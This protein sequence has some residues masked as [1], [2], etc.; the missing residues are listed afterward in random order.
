MIQSRSAFPPG[1]TAHASGLKSVPSPRPQNVERW[2]VVCVFVLM[3][4]SVWF[5]GAEGDDDVMRGSALAQLLWGIVYLAGVVGLLRNRDKLPQLMRLSLPIVAIVGLATISTAWSIDPG[6]TLK[7]AFGLFGTTAFGYYIVSRY[8]LEDFI[9]I[10]GLTCCVV[11]ALSLLAV[12]LVPSIGVMQNEYAGAWRGIFSH[13]NLFG[14]FMALAFVTFATILLSKEWRRG[15]AAA[16][17]LLAAFLVIQSKS[18]TAWV[19][20]IAVAYALGLTVLYRRSVRGRLAALAIAGATLF[21][22][23]GLLAYGGGSQVLLGLVGRDETFTGRADFWPQVMQAI[24][25]HPLLGYGYSAFWLPN[26]AFS[27][28]IRSGFIPAH[29]HNGYLEAC[30][31]FG[32]VG[33]ALGALAILIAIRRSAALLA[34]AL[35]PSYTWPFLTV[36]YFAIINLTESSIAKYNNF[37]WI[38]F[39]VAFLYASQCLVL[40]SNQRRAQQGRAVSLR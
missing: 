37:N 1:G 20:S 34:R 19:V 7:R 32:I 22:A 27:Y 15:T 30:L 2:F 23:F 29:A 26:G 11:I 17:A 31:D 36:I 28:F 18:V 39:V 33:S 13:K 40:L 9:D 25:F 3:G 6:I 38:I 8:K 24:S 5:T 12:F 10:L 4:V 16:G 21:A 14:E 35:N